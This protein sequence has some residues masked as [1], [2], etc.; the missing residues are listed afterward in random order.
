MTWEELKK[1]FG[2]EYKDMKSFK[3]KFIKAVRDVLVLY[4]EAKVEIVPTGL[5]FRRSNP[6]VPFMTK[7][8]IENKGQD[9]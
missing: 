8:K 9:K 3:Q 4:H 6:S 5:R 1:L 2:Q 7:K